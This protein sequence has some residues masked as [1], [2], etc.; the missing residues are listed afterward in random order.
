MIRIKNYKVLE[1]MLIHPAHPKLIELL[2]WICV[3]YSEVVFTG[4]YEDRDYPSTHSTIP[5]R[6][7]DIRSWIYGEPQKVTDDINTHWIYDSERREL[8]CAVYHDTGKGKHIHLQVHDNTE[9]RSG[10]TQ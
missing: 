7:M 10:P 4:M 8:K 5:V 9:Y 2:E 3:R 1:S 6:A